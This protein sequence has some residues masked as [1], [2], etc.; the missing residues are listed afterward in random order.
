MGPTYVEALVFPG[1]Y[2]PT[3]INLTCNCFSKANDLDWIN[4]NAT[5]LQITVY[6]TNGRDA[7]S[8][9]IVLV[10]YFENFTDVRPTSSFRV[11]IRPTLVIQNNKPPY[12]EPPL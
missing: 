10:Q 4:H 9:L 5:N 1:T 3:T 2:L 12:F 7:G 11:T 6:T 8:Y